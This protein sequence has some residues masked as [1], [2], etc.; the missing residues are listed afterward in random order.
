MQQAFDT[1]KNK[2]LI[3]KLE[4]DVHDVPLSWFSDYIN[5]KS[6]PLVMNNVVPWQC[7]KIWCTIVLCIMRTKH[8]FERGTK[9]SAWKFLSTNNCVRKNFWKSNLNQIITN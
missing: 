1:V 6:D 2:M 9:S 3:S 7:L 5:S 8:A 4:H